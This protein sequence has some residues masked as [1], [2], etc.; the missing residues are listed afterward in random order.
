VNDIRIKASEKGIQTQGAV[1]RGMHQ[2]VVTKLVAV[3]M[4]ALDTMP[5]N[6]HLPTNHPNAVD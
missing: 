5:Q 1:L 4:T 2:T 6:T 3:K